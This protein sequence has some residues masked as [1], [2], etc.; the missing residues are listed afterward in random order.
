[1]STKDPLNVPISNSTVRVSIIDTTIDGDIPTAPFMGPPIPGFERW[2]AV[3]YAFLVTHT[4][5][6]GNVR[7]VVFDLGLPK[8]LANDFP[9]PVIEATVEI[10]VI[11]TAEKY[12]SEILSENGVSL[13]DIEAL[14]LR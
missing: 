6:D 2:R 3:G 11:M 8:D 12:V 10:G 14:I 13:E 4:D 1:M 7:R 9:P 5:A